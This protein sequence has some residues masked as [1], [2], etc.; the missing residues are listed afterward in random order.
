MVHW[1]STSSNPVHSNKAR[2]LRCLGS[3]PN[4]NLRHYAT[5]SASSKKNFGQCIVVGEWLS[6]CWL[7]LSLGVGLAEVHAQQ[8]CW[9]V[10]LVICDS[11]C[12]CIGHHAPMVTELMSALRVVCCLGSGCWYRHGCWCRMMLG[13][14]LVLVCGLAWLSVVD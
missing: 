1:Y 3:R 6:G 7:Q 9:E 12:G 13:S 11:V 4:Q 10:T 14:V 2:P 8:G 5:G